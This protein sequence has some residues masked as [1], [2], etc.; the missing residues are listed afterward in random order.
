MYPAVK[1]NAVSEAVARA[2]VGEAV[3]RV[4]ALDC[5]PTDRVIDASYELIELSASVD[6]EIDGD[7]AVLTVYYLVNAD[8]YNNTED[9]RDLDYS[10]RT[11]IIN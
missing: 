7:E 10:D 5:S 11:F 8:D 6:C 3:D 4:L 9:M 1:S 2:Q